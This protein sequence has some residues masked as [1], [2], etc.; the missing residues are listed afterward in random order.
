M[1]N[2]VDVVAQQIELI[3]NLSQDI[4]YLILA[5]SILIGV[6]LAYGTLKRVMQG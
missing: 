4:K 6:L 2:E 3:S 5:V 1:E